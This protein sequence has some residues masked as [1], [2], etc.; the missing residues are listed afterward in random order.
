M[1]EDHRI[2]GYERTIRLAV[3]DLGA[4]S[5]GQKVDLLLDNYADIRDSNHAREI[6]C[7]IST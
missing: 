7:A 1:I 3:R 4:L 6:L 5:S 2:S